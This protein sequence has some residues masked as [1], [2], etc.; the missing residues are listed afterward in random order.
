VRIALVLRE[1]DSSN[2]LA[3]RRT[4]YLLAS[5]GL[6][7]FVAILAHAASTGSRITNSFA[8]F[9]TTDLADF[10]VNHQVCYFTHV[11]TPPAAS[12]RAR[13]S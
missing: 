11:V 3:A 9:F 2:L 13:E 8:K 7:S 12:R 5:L 4:R 6:L 1:P 10:S